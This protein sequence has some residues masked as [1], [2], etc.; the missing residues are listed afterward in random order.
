M[1]YF[2]YGSGRP[3]GN[4]AG[5][6][7]QDQSNRP[8]GAR[9]IAGAPSFESLRAPSN[10]RIRRL[11][12]SN[13]V[14][15]QQRTGNLQRPATQ[16]AATTPRPDDEEDELPG[17]RR[18]SS[19]PQRPNYDM[20][21]RNDLARQRTTDA[22]APSHMPAIREGESVTPHGAAM[23]PGFP[24]ANAGS[25]PVTPAGINAQDMAAATPPPERLGPGG[26]AMHSAG[27]AAQRN[28]GFSLSRFRSNTSSTAPRIIE[29]PGSQQ[30]EYESDVI[31]LLDLV[32][33]EVRT[34]G[35]L[36]NLQNSLF[37]PD[38]GGLVNRR[39]TYDLSR[40]STGGFD[41]GEVQRIARSRAGT[42]ASRMGQPP[43]QKPIPEEEGGEQ[44]G[45]ELEESRIR[46]TISISSQLSDSHYAV[47][48]HGVSLEGWT[49]EDVAELNDHVRHLLHSKREGFKRSMRG[50]KQYISKP[51]GLFV[52]VYATCVTLFGAAWVFALIGWIY[53][54]N[55][56][57]YIINV[58]D[59]VLVALFALIGDGLA[60]F[61]AVDTYHMCFI[62]HYHH[63]TWRLRREKQLPELVDQNDLPD[64]RRSA[65]EAEIED[66]IDKEEMAEFSVLSPKQ[67]KRLQYHQ[68]KFN[69]SHTF[70]KP[71]ETATH[72][73]FPLRHMV[74]A[75]VLLDCHSLLQVALGTCT[76]SINYHTRP[77]ALTATI[78]SCS[79][80]CNIAAGVVISI[81]DH[82][83]R[84][85]DVLER[86]FR[87]GLT[88]QALRRM[89][90][91]HGRGEMAIAVDPQKVESEDIKDAHKAVTQPPEPS[92]A[93]RAKSN[94]DVVPE[95]FYTP[96]ER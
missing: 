39:P 50:F 52:F 54:G 44:D 16:E 43:V 48:P 38:L 35:T 58:I 90:K 61:R 32:D 24:G 23:H 65:T 20:L 69:K 45:I 88:E 94:G 71:H 70:Y 53:A 84:K 77:E 18:S 79:I 62:A 63:T 47:L 73:A 8:R 1:D 26:T 92:A 2:N 31:D 10:I 22:A 80:A 72:H 66:A 11:P 57:D 36:T 30:D 76:W 68:A 93:E 28:R 81:G 95:E 78:L 12:S 86:I 25:R 91:K 96:S 19:A 17:R 37:V 14:P 6:Q 9:Y 42:R 83:T 85:K 60:P 40:R 33:P 4:N 75:V 15:G 74:A 49:D 55:R 46:R 29:R 82:K 13:A 89:A 51:L 56:Q 7:P 67:Q 59:L 64:R 21:M 3:G 27:N 41:E 34:L 5:N 87:Q